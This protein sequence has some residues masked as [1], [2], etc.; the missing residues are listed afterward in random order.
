MGEMD[1]AALERALGDLGDDLE[2]P[3]AAGVVPAVRARLMEAPARGPRLRRRLALAAVALAIVVTGAVTLSPDARRAV[4]GWLG[5]RGVGIRLEE[6]PPAPAGPGRLELGERVTFEE[7]SARAPFRVLIPSALGPPDEVY[8]L[9]GPPGGG[10]ALVWRPGPGLPEAGETG[11]GLLLTA[12]RAR[13]GEQ[14]L[15]KS[16][17]RVE[18]VGVDGRPG[19][20]IEGAPHAVYYLDDRGEVREETL[21]LAGNTLLWE[22]DELTLRIEGALTKEGALRIAASVR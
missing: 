20:W 16:A 9:A 21:R 19:Y 5:L 4:A 11:V 14:L 7:A 1:L 17:A 13:A 22:R 10:V 15:G 6:R 3:P 12:F 8:V 18:A 2:F